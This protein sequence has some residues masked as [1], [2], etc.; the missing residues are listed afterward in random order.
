MR[1]PPLMRFDLAVAVVSLTLALATLVVIARGDQVNLTPLAV[2]PAPSAA[3]VSTRATV[4]VR[5]ARP[6]LPASVETAWRIEPP[7]PGRL[8]WSGNTLTWTPSQPLVA[9]TTYRVTLAPGLA[10]TSGRRARAPYSWHFTTRAA[11]LVTLRRVD[12]VTNLWLI[13]PATGQARPLTRERADVIDFSPAP[14]SSRI[15]YTRQDSPTQTSVWTVDVASGAT[16][17]LSPDEPATFAAPAWS[18]DGHLIILE[19]RQALPGTIANPK[20]VAVRPDGAPA[21]LIYGR[22]DEVGFGARWSPDGARLAFFDPVRQALVVFNFTHDRVLIPVQT[23]GAFA[24]SPDSRRLVIEDI[25]TDGG[26]FQHVLRLAD[27]I[28]GASE[29]L[30]AARDVDEATP[31]W[32]PDGQAIA[33]TRRPTTGAITGAQPML[34]R[35]DGGAVRPLLPTGASAA[36]ETVQLAWSPDGRQLL[37]GQL[38]LHDPGAEIQLWLADATGSAPPRALG[39]GGAAAWLP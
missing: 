13:D 9:E 18:P 2:S 3:G 32:S 14:D 4:H 35:L 16:S 31:V 1:R 15:A 23:A 6:M 30:T 19:R 20:L 27:A 8:A 26:A 33:F 22:G 17:R 28:T 38:P 24:W 34:R 36:L 11:W 7:A 29:R 12:G 21:G 25:I 5:F 10:E 39:P 37:L